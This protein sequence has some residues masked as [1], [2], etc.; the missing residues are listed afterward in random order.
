MLWNNPTKKQFQ[1]Y[2]ITQSLLQR[3][4]DTR[5]EQGMDFFIVRS[6]VVLTCRKLQGYEQILEKT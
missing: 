2:P 5:A 6:Y 4:E 1:D 3:L